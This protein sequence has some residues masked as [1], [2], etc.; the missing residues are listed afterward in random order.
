MQQLSAQQAAA[1]WNATA[2][3]QQEDETPESD[4]FGALTTETEDPPTLSPATSPK[5]LSALAA[6]V[7]STLEPAELVGRY[8]NFAR[9]IELR[10]N[11][12]MFPKAPS[13]MEL[14]AAALGDW[15]HPAHDPRTAAGVMAC[16]IAVVKTAGP[17]APIATMLYDGPM[18]ILETAEATKLKAALP[19]NLAA[20]T[21]DRFIHGVTNL[22][23][24]IL[25]AQHLLL[26]RYP[27]E[28]STT[29][30]NQ[31]TKPTQT[32]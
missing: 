5:A 15:A 2:Q 20:K 3:P 4:T 1:L 26:P 28:R 25:T 27:T 19:G 31:P 11:P 30:S 6:A 22:R 14:I 10:F 32:P 23:N 8:N 9:W 7:A 29:C 18:R 21:H 13:A 12:R 24:Y 16:F 17:V